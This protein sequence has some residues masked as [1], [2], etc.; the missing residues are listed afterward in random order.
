MGHPVP[1]KKPGDLIVYLRDFFPFNCCDPGGDEPR[2]FRYS[3]FDDITALYLFDADTDYAA[4]VWSKYFFGKTGTF[5]T[6]CLAGCEDCRFSY[7]LVR[8]LIRIYE[9]DDGAVHVFFVEES[10]STF[11]PFMFKHSK[12][13]YDTWLGNECTGCLY[14]GNTH[15]MMCNNGEVKVEQLP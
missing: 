12:L 2:R 8:L 7:T 10:P 14:C 1:K 6:E 15:L 4:G 3:S 9:A 11:G 13:I 5:K